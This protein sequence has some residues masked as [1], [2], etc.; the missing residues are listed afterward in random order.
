MKG[1]DTNY[2]VECPICKGTGLYRKDDKRRK[3]NFVEF[4]NCPVCDGIGFI[5]KQE[6]K[7]LYPGN[8]MNI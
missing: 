5:T 6:Y 1:Y 2:E 7:N 3:N 4:V 8:Y